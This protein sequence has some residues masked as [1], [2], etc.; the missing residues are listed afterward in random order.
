MN[1]NISIVYSPNH[2]LHAPPIQFAEGESFTHPEQPTRIDN[3]LKALQTAPFSINIYSTV[4]T[5]TR[6]QLAIVHSLDYLDYLH[7]LAQKLSSRKGFYF[8]PFVFPIRQYMERLKGSTVGRHGYYCYDTCAPVGE[9]TWEAASSAAFSALVAAKMTLNNRTKIIYALCRP[10]GHHAGIDFFGGYCYINNAALIARTISK[11][12]KVAIIDLDYH[13]GNGTQQI[14][15]EDEAVWTGS[16]HGHPDYEYPFYCG[17]EDEIGSGKGLGLNSNFPLPSNTQ[18][19]QYLDVLDQ[20]LERLIKFAPEWLVVPLG[21]DTYSRDREG[22]FNLTKACYTKIGQRLGELR[23][24][25]VIVQ[26]GGY[27]IDQLGDLAVYFFNGL[28]NSV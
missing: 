6:E 11:F 26:E 14:F 22:E 27:C 9:M 17:Y 19:S 23:L 16:I 8:N 28:I 20:Q 24:P 10:P 3:I 18:D 5:A 2:K 7:S 25:L 21:F 12:G 1:Q 15:W 4:Q 13:H